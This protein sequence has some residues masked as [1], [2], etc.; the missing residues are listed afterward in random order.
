MIPRD[1]KT[2]EVDYWDERC[3]ASAHQQFVIGGP[4]EGPDVIP[5]PAIAGIGCPAVHVAYELNEIE[6][7]A[8]AQG[9]TLW[10]STWGGLPIH[11]VEV[12]PRTYDCN[13]APVDE[14]LERVTDAAQAA[15]TALELNAPAEAVIALKVALEA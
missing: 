13:R 5:C 11:R 10:L 4:A 1:A 2:D 3:G 6:V 7:A 12:I 8:L 9:G 15:L 14:R